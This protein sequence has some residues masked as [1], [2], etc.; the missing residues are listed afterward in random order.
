MPLRPCRSV[1]SRRLAALPF[2]AREVERFG[3]QRPQRL[4]AVGCGLEPVRDWMNTEHVH[5]ERDFSDLSV[6]EIFLHHRVL[7]VPVTDEGVVVGVIT[8]ADFFR[9]VTERFLAAARSSPP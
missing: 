7:L 8:R 4:V 5:V 1:A 3:E 6:A 9:S 2:L